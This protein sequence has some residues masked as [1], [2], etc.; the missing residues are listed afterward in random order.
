MDAQRGTVSDSTRW[1][2]EEAPAETQPDL[3]EDLHASAADVTVDEDEIETA[4]LEPSELVTNDVQTDPT[5]LTVR[6]L[7][8]SSASTSA[9][10]HMRELARLEEA[11]LIDPNNIA[12][13]QALT[14]RYEAIEAWEPL[15][16]IMWAR[17]NSVRNKNARADVIRR[18]AELL[19][20]KLH[21]FAGAVDAFELLYLESPTTRTLGDIARLSE[22]LHHWDRAISARAEIARQ[23]AAGLD[24]AQVYLDL[25][26]TMLP[27]EPLRAKESFEEALRE[28]PELVEA[29]DG[30]IAIA[31]GGTARHEEASLRVA[32]AN[33]LSGST[34]AEDYAHAARLY[35]E[36]G[37]ARCA[38]DAWA[39]AHQQ[40]PDHE[41]AASY[42][43]DRYVRDKKWAEAAPLA[44]GLVR[45]AEASKNPEK[46]AMRRQ[47]AQMI[48][49]GMGDT[50]RAL[51]QAISAFEL[52]PRD[53]ELALGMLRATKHE[54]RSASTSE[55]AGPALHAIASDLFVL[56]FDTLLF[57]AEV[58]RS[59]GF[60]NEAVRVFEHVLQIDP[61]HQAA[62][63]ELVSLYRALERVD[64]AARIK[65]SL[66]ELTTDDE[67]RFVGLVELAE[68]LNHEAHDL[69]GAAI[70]YEEA[71][72]LRPN[73]PWILQTLAW[74]Y[75]ELGDPS[76]L[77]S[78]LTA[79]TELADSPELRAEASETLGD[80][81]LRELNDPDRAAKLFESALQLDR[82]RTSAFEKLARLLRERHDQ[83]GLEAA[84]L[85]MIERADARGDEWLLFALYKDLGALYRDGFGDVPRAIDAFDRATRLRSENEDAR[86]ALVDLYV[87]QGELDKAISR[88]RA[89]LEERPLSADLYAELYHLYL[90]QRAN[91]RAWCVVD[92]LRALK[93]LTPQQ[94]KFRTDFPP[95]PLHQIGGRLIDQA[96]GSHILHPDLDPLLTRIFSIVAKRVAPMASELRDGPSQPRNLIP[97]TRA[98]SHLERDISLWF[99]NAAE[100]L[101]VPPPPLFVGPGSEP[102]PFWPSLGRVGSV[103]VNAA[104]AESLTDLLVYLASTQVAALRP[105]L[106]A[107]TY[108]P[109][110][111]SLGSLLATAIQITEDLSGRAKAAARLSDTDFAELRALVDRSK[112]LGKIHDVRL[113]KRCAALSEMRAG[114]LLT[115]DA[116]I[117]TR[118]IQHDITTPGDLTLEERTRELYRFATSERYFEL[119]QAIG[120]SL[121]EGA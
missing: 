118:A 43:I 98:Y 12:A 91:D 72:A 107:N 10:P 75:S 121:K 101:G 22:H 105:E 50:R 93:R 1:K 99:G 11:L 51:A 102:R 69:K 115:Q 33:L 58:L 57:L 66:L 40:N 27:F 49:S 89:G 113:W 36:L 83:K 103:F 41:E 88:V 39:A 56:P 79:L 95:V 45:S 119:R 48:Y 65:R 15:V 97:F 112:E 37:E 25:G 62:L 16:K 73:D 78:V 3:V 7:D 5:P 23:R 31:E 100:I 21:N 30:L 34:A 77:A 110:T 17:A 68:M 55:L 71:W 32:R 29:Y 19:E 52:N 28:S 117:A 13:M 74:V 14:H 108:F 38:F 35:E 63:E 24:R 104:A 70:A 90:R 120:I 2:K 84:L 111:K 86:R 42:L 26:R 9:V 92:V 96:W 81:C 8:D 109:T 54:A 67:Q 64:D 44:E 59:V 6:E 53:P 46:I 85:R 18:I 80:L 82:T 114:F 4:D 116:S 94:A 20:T 87:I 76:H 60:A 47:T 106:S 61:A